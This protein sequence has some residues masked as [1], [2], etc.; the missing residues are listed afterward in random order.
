[1]VPS[2]SDDVTRTL[3]GFFRGGSVYVFSFR[4]EIKQNLKRCGDVLFD[5]LITSKGD[6]AL[7]ML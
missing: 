3:R 6:S 7:G 5:I 1:M 4:F 2:S